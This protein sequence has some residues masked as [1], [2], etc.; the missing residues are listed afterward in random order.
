MTEE[1]EELGTIKIPEKLFSQLL[2]HV[3]G[4]KHLNTEHLVHVILVD[5]LRRRERTFDNPTSTI[6]KNP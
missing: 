6:R 3:D 2:E 5:W 4:I 1:T